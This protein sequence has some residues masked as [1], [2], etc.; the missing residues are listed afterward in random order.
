[1]PDPIIVA[2]NITKL[3]PFRHKRKMRRAESLISYLRKE[4]EFGK[5][6]NMFKALDNVN[7]EVYPGEC[8]AIIGQNGSGKSTLLRVLTGITQPSS[9][10]AF[11]N[12]SF[13]ELFSLNSGFDKDLS[14]RQNIYLYSALKGI[15]R[16]EIETH[17]EDIIAF[18]EL[19]D[20]IDQPIK[21][22]SSG[23]R[24]RLGFSLMTAILPKVM[25][26]D[27]A[28]GT[29][30]VRFQAKCNQRIEAMTRDKS[31]TFVIVS[32]SM[33]NLRE[34]CSRAIWLDKGVLKLDG[35]VDEVIDAY[36]ENGSQK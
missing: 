15:S 4:R 12:G 25:F 9:G 14:G 35:A 5:K 32:H 29:G 34:L 28:L 11:V 26:I 6:R 19:G 10:Y 33:N 36:L 24:S 7:F 17:I 31:R 3:Y 8:V 2:K 30:D 22:Y 21:T 23:M 20:F 13:G 27:E 1:M 18:S 16:N